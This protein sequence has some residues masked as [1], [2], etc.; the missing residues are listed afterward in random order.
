MDTYKIKKSLDAL[1]K[2]PDQ[3]AE[4]FS[5]YRKAIETARASE[6]VSVGAG[7]QEIRDA[8]NRIAVKIQNLKE[9]ALK[10][11]AF[12][13]QANNEAEKTVQREVRLGLG[14]RLDPETDQQTLLQETREQRAWARIKPV[15]D[16][17]S[18][19]N[20]PRVVEEMA[21]GFA[22]DGDADSI[23]AVAGELT[24]Y[25]KARFAQSKTG[26]TTLG[27][28]KQRFE[29]ALAGNFP[30]GETALAFKRELETGMSNL[31]FGLDSAVYGIEQGEW[32]IIVP[33]WNGKHLEVSAEG[34]QEAQNIGSFSRSR[35]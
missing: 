27:E 11:L 13:R 34:Y 4:I 3:I 26:D 7:G 21:S 20:F 25:A 5:N 14:F 19:E 10:E 29:N 33:T 9:A 17:T 15:F 6:R 35:L 2:R 23:A 24:L 16:Q 1:L 31:K 30:D 18:E 8:E 12:L 22:S 28:T 32:A